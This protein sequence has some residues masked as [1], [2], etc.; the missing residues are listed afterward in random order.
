MADRLGDPWLGFCSYCGGPHVPAGGADPHKKCAAAFFDE[1]PD[2][3]GVIEHAPF[4]PSCGGDNSLAVLKM[5]DPTDRCHYCHGAMEEAPEDDEP[6]SG[7]QEADELDAKT[8]HRAHPWIRCGACGF[9]GI[10]HDTKS[11]ACPTPP[12]NGVLP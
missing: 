2:S 7:D 12:R 4:C 1:W 9:K 8:Y 5:R 10:D 6:I 3:R 11:G